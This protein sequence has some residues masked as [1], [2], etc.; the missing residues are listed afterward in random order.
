MR[1]S[2]WRSGSPGP[3]AYRSLGAAASETFLDFGLRAGQT[4]AARA[5]YDAS[6][7]TYRQTVLTGFQQVEDNLAALRILKE[8]AQEQDE[9]VR[10]AKV[11]LAVSTDQYKAGTI[12]LSPSWWWKTRP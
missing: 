1:P 4:A 10:D 6:V 3:A 7:A 12:A 2:A 11:S 5:S 8:E 9:A